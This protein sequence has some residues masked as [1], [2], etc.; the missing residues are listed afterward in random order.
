MRHWGA[1]VTGFYILIVAGLSPFVAWLMLSIGEPTSVSG[2]AQAYSN[3]FVLA[4]IPLL[5]GGPLVLLLVHADP[6]RMRL[7]PRRHIAVSAA[8][9][10]FALS[11]LVLAAAASI[12]VVLRGDN[13][14]DADF[15]IVLASW[16][17]AWLVWALVFWRMG[18]RLFEPTTRIHR[19]LVKGSVL[20]LLVAV[21]SYLIVRQRHECTAPEVTAFG[22][23]TGLAILLM[24]LGPGTWFLYRACARR[25]SPPPESEGT[26]LDP[27]ASH[28]G[29]QR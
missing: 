12:V 7:R 24:S 19:W 6:A 27:G 23:V 9:A 1:V 17:S 4:W 28:D 10:G 18:E 3:W 13:W 25:Y 16:P 14:E 20:E 26:R 21:P 29:D 5:A 11:L 8:A 15:W 2:L 22:V